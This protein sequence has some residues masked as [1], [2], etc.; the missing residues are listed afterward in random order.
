MN[1]RIAEEVRKTV[2]AALVY[3]ADR[4][5]VRDAAGDDVQ[6]R[7]EPNGSIYLCYTSDNRSTIKSCTLT[8]GEFLKRFRPMIETQPCRKC[9]DCGSEEFEA[10]TTEHDRCVGCDNVYPAE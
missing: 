9:P 1:Q 3:T 5:W 4:F 6:I 7:L 2:S 10:V 8:W